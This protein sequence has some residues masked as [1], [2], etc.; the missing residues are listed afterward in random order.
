[1]V[2]GQLICEHSVRCSWWSNCAF[3]GFV[4]A[5]ESVPITKNLLAFGICEVDPV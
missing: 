3:S 1:M 2:Q 5:K 4:A